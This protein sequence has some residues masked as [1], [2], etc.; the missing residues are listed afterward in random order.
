VRFPSSALARTHPRPHPKEENAP[1]PAELRRWLLTG[2]SYMIPFVAAG[3]VL[4]ALGYLLGGY[5]AAAPAADLVARYS[6]LHP[7]AGGLGRYL[8]AVLFVLGTAAFGFLVPALA[9][10]I[11]FAVAGR[12]GLMPGFTVGL[13]ATTTGAGYLGGLVAG[14]LAG[15]VARW[16]AALPLPRWARGL[17]PLVLAPLGATLLAGGLLVLVLARPLAAVTHG[18]DSWLLGLAATSAALLGAVLGAMM[19]VDLGGPLNKAAYA[20]ATVGLSATAHARPEILAAVMAAGMV[21]PLALALATALRPAAFSPGEREHGKAAW[22]LGAA[23]VTEGAIPFA[24]ADPVRVIPPIVLGAATAGAVS[25]AAS[26]TLRAPHG[27]LF[28]LF[29]VGGV[30]LFLTALA[31][32][33]AVAAAAVLAAKAKRPAAA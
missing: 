27:G 19:A 26:V 31:A 2:V 18:L 29:A 3:G 21:P 4:Q 23:F 13:V 5:Q 30:A 28:A 17:Q 22:L 32:G 12:P 10:Y 24:A 20:F 15:L 6:L 1:R 33:T 25:M 11:A 7:P 8:G 9:G 14:V 16:L